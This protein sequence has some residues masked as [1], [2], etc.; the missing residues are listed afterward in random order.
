[1]TFVEVVP[2][3][4]LVACMTVKPPPPEPTQN[5]AV[6]TQPIA[7]PDLPVVCRQINEWTTENFPSAQTGVLGKQPK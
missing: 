3:F 6:P 7:R 4:A 5:K 2:L 1:M